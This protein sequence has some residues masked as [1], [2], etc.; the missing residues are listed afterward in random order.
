MPVKSVRCKISDSLTC[1]RWY[2]LWLSAMVIW[3]R[4][5][6]HCLVKSIRQIK[7]MKMKKI[8][9]FYIVQYHQSIP[10]LTKQEPLICN[11][12]VLMRNLFAKNRCGSRSYW[13]S[14]HLRMNARN[15]RNSRD[16]WKWWCSEIS[17]CIKQLNWLGLL[18]KKEGWSN[19]IK[20]SW[21]WKKWDK[22]STKKSFSLLWKREKNLKMNAEKY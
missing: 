11:Q 5:S 3:K 19:K 15:L 4:L 21:K 16:N 12:P 1:R 17:K 13:C 18:K 8:T 9:N 20:I 2:S 14:L 6:T 22:R 10:S 7:T